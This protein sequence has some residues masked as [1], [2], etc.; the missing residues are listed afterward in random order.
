MGVIQG[1]PV[2]SDSGRETRPLQRRT[3]R[4]NTE[5]GAGLNNEEIH[6]PE[7]LTYP[8]ASPVEDHIP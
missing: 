5:H 2:L 6:L 8:P 7:A 4:L 3:D 1:H